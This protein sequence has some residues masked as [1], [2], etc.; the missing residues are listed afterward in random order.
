MPKLPNAERAV[1]P[2]EKLRDYSLNRAHEK[3]KHKARVFHAAL[4]FTETDAGRLRLMILEAA[5]REE[6]TKGESLFY[7]QM[8]R[9]DFEVQMLERAATIRTTWIVREGEDFPRMVS[10]FVKGKER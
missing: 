6:A 4:G 8:Y 1:V 7:G 2:I 5:Q 10:C 3:G 9:V